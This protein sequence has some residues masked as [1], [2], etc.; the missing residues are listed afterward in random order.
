MDLLHNTFHLMDPPHA[1]FP[2]PDHTSAPRNH[3]N[4][5]HLFCPV[6][7]HCTCKAE[8]RKLKQ[9]YRQTDNNDSLLP[10]LHPA[11]QP[12]DCYLDD[13]ASNNDTYYHSKIR[14]RHLSI[15]SWESHFHRSH[16]RNNR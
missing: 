14:I 4:P 16:Y 3:T 12:H 2:I 10:L 13:P 8:Q 11:I 15:K 9:R 6:L 1:I 7:S 5:I